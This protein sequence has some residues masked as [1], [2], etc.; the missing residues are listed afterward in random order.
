MA[1]GAASRCCVWLFYVLMEQE[2][3]YFLLAGRRFSV[4]GNKGLFFGTGL[5]TLVAGEYR[6]CLLFLM[7]LLV[8]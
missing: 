7:I 1:L 2:V 4:Q 3:N 6:A 5:G 8:R